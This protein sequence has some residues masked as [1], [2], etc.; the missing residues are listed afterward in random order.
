MAKR[1]HLE[2]RTEA[3][4]GDRKSTGGGASAKSTDSRK[5]ERHGGWHT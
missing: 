4:E 2:S 3:H 5:K 1:P